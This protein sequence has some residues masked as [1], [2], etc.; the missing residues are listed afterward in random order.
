ML[1]SGKPS[2][3]RST[4]L[5]WS[6]QR[7]PQAALIKCPA[8]E[9]F[10]GGARG[11]GKT[12]GMLGKFAF[13]AQRYGEH[14]IGVFFRRSREDLKEAIER[15]RQIYGPI[16]ATWNE[17]KKWWTFPNGARLKFEYLDR[18][19]DADNYQGHNYTDIFFEELT[20]WLIRRR[21]TN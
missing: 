11:G 7:G 6:P 2:T 3:P 12:D 14:T 4:K 19:A 8:D 5:V 18:D 16:G 15:S 13:K 10:Y 20:H 17:Q 9:I 21:S 1:S